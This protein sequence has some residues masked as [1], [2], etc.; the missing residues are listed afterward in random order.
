MP[1]TGLA[2]PSPIAPAPAAPMARD[3]AGGAGSAELEALR[4]ELCV[5]RARIERFKTEAAACIS[6]AG[7]PCGPQTPR[8]ARPRPGAP[9]IRPFY[10]CDMGPLAARVRRWDRRWRARSTRCDRMNRCGGRAAPP[11]ARRGPADSRAFA[12]LKR[13]FLASGSRPPRGF[14]AAA[15]RPG[16]PWVCVCWS[17]GR[18]AAAGGDWLPLKRPVRLWVRLAILLWCAHWR[19]RYWLL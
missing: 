13:Q 9:K 19:R 12:V 15:R 3:G 17:W 5:S 7:R 1:P 10:I 4:E 6:D 14:F 11:D 8:P 18:A 16:H 2:P